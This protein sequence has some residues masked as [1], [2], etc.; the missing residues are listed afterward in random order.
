[1]S[2]SFDGKKILLS[3]AEQ[4]GFKNKFDLVSQHTLFTHPK[5]VLQTQKKN[6]FKIIRDLPNRGKIIEC[7]GHNV[8]ACDNTGPQHTFEW[9]NGNIRKTDIQINHVYAASKNF[10]IYTSLANLCATPIFIAKLT[11]TDYEVKN[12]LRYRIFDLY[13]F[14]MEKKPLKPEGYDKLTWMPFVQ[15]LD[16]VEAFLKKRLN[17]CSKSR[18]TKSCKLLGWYYSDYLPDRSLV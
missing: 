16:N 7:N 15:P 14:F 3:I 6:L 18:T 10:E 1:M 2:V 5:I 9:C 8:M 4:A 11:D 17:A 12:L 13:D